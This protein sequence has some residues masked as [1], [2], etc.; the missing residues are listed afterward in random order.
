MDCPKPHRRSSSLVGV[1][2]I[3]EKNVPFSR[4]CRGL[5]FQ[6]MWK[7]RVLYRAMPNTRQPSHK[8]PY[9]SDRLSAP[10]MRSTMLRGRPTSPVPLQAP[11]LPMVMQVPRT[12]EGSPPP[13]PS[14]QQ[15][16]EKMG[17]HLPVLHS[18]SQRRPMSLLASARWWSHWLQRWRWSEAWKEGRTGRLWIK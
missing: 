4:L 6:V 12:T 14:L 15:R 8:R 17:D 18:S 9:Q 2:L 16:S 5:S 13:P 1:I 10:E 11:V 3:C 7:G